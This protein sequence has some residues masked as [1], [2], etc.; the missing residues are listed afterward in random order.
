MIQPGCGISDC[1]VINPTLEQII[2]IFI[3]LLGDSSCSHSM[4][5]TFWAESVKNEDTVSF[6]SVNED[7][8]NITAQMGNNCLLRLVDE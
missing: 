3:Q 7:D 8:R 2:S 1:K 4:A 5:V 6:T